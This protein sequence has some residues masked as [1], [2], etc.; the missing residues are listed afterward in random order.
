MKRR[1]LPRF[2]AATLAL[3]ILSSDI[4]AF[5]LSDTTVQQTEGIE[6]ELTNELQQTESVTEEKEVDIEEI[7]NF[8][9]LILLVQFA[10]TKQEHS[11][12]SDI[13][14]IF[15]GTEE[16]SEGL[17]Q[18]L[19]ALSKNT[20]KIENLIPQYDTETNEFS[21]FT[22][23]NTEQYYAENENALL[24]E[25]AL[26]LNSSELLTEEMILHYGN[27]E[28]RLDW[29]TILVPDEAENETVHFETH[30]GEYQHEL[31]EEPLKIGE[32][33]I[34]NYQIVTE[35]DL[36]STEDSYV[37]ISQRIAEHL[38]LIETDVS[39]CE[40]KVS[41]DETELLT[42]PI[43]G[44]AVEVAEFIELDS[45]AEIE[46]IELQEEIITGIQTGARYFD[47]GDFEPAVPGQTQNTNRSGGGAEK[48][49]RLFKL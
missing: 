11:Y 8:S 9:H 2:L 10:D 13:L 25:I 1:L 43:Q 28:S 39:E 41:Q 32:D 48:D 49:G 14:E 44:E 20:L 24:E 5:A 47:G 6:E 15:N 19:Y 17:R 16:S 21:V 3:V 29:L 23:E 46:D 45:S 22:L 37:L 12:A 42:E 34:V 4:S 35:A 36:Y 40:E 31:E 33:S 30:V 38:E 18:Y 27:E 7:A 26:R